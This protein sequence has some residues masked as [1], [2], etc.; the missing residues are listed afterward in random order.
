M[1]YDGHASRLTYEQDKSQGKRNLWTVSTIS[2]TKKYLQG[3]ALK[4]VGV[5]RSHPVVVP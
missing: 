3:V 2:R 4:E 5:D 1:L